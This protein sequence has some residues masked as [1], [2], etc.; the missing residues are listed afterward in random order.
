MTTPA[1]S[2]PLR[3]ETYLLQEGSGEIIDFLRALRDRG[4]Q[5]VEPRP[6]LTGADGR[7]V[8]LPEPMFEVLL[9]VAVAMEAGLAVTVAP[10]HL[11]LS[12][13]EA[14]DLLRVSRTTLVRLLE[15][16]ASKHSG[17]LLMLLW[18][19]GFGARR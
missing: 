18:V 16:G 9:Q 6:R 8:E 13:Q 2:E 17:A 15:T 14:A 12:T 1:R 4:R 19:A 7:S 11:T 5:A 10:H 3:D